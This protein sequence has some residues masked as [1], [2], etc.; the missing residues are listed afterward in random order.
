MKVRLITL[1]LLS[2][3]NRS[4]LAIDPAAGQVLFGVISSKWPVKGY[5]VIEQFE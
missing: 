5:L 1:N 3:H 4:N 2:G